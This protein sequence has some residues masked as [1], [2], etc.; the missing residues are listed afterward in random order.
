MFDSLRI[1]QTIEQ[2]STTEMELS[3]TDASDVA[4]HMTDWLGDLEAL[5]KFYQ[6]PEALSPKEASQLL[7]P[8]SVSSS[9][10]GDELTRPKGV[11]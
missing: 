5:V 4:F 7:I 3:P 2:I 9:P 8:D 1:Q 10:N 11:L 6:N